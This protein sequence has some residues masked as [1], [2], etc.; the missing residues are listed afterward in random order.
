MTI[1]FK[2]LIE[3]DGLAQWAAG[4]I[5]EADLRLPQREFCLR[6]IEPAAACAQ[7]RALHALL[8]EA[9]K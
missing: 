6:Y 2:V 9:P 8:N 1:R 4:D 7:N 3:L 5:T